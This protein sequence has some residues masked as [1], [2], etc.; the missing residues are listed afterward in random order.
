MD[1]FSEEKEDK[2]AGE[3]EE[4]IEE[5]E[6]PKKNFEGDDIEFD[7]NIDIEQIEKALQLQLEGGEGSEKEV[8][9][10]EISQQELTVVTFEEV[11]PQS[12]Q[13]IPV[14]LPNTFSEISPG[15]KKYVVYINPENV[16]F[17]ENLSVNA[18]RDIINKI[19]REQDE[20]VAKKRDAERKKQYTRH[21]IVAV[22][23]FIIGFPIL[24]FIVNKSVEAT[25][26]NYKQA[27][28]NFINLYR[29]KGKIQPHIN[30]H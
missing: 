11:V 16:D 23:T 2:L 27:Q 17:M 15:S 19:L 8:V 4:I 29:E 12:E 3:E 25:I 7:E 28:K 21:L 1:N 22:M 6:P 18:R 10:E 30:N 24:F 5:K 13:N 26:A 14:P 20:L 9:K